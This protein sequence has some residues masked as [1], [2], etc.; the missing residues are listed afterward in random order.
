[1]RVPRGSF[2]PDPT[3]EYNTRRSS[4]AG[5]PVLVHVHLFDSKMDLSLQNSRRE[6]T[7]SGSLRAA[8]PTAILQS[9]SSPLL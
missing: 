4:I 9:H 2:S 5:I 6:R 8:V 7:R 3:A 1:M